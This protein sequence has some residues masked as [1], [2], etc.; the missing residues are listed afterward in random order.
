MVD[1]S[2]DGNMSSSSNLPVVNIKTLISF[3]LMDSTYLV[4]KQVFLTILES[5]DVTSHVNEIGTI[6]PQT[7]DTSDKKTIINPKYLNWK[8]KETTI[9]S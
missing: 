9:L 2:L 7:I 6:L 5:F 8:R 4:W 3:E 1:F